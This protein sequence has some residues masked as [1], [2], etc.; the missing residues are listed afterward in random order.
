LNFVKIP[1]QT[2]AWLYCSSGILF[3]SGVIWAVFHYF[4]RSSSPFEQIISPI[5][6]LS[7]K[8]HGAA[9][10]AF[11][12]V[13]GAL[14]PIHMRRAWRGKRNKLSGM[15]ILATCSLLILTGYALYYWGEPASRS[16]ISFIHLGIGILL[17]V[18]LLVHA[19][20]GKSVAKKAELLRNSEPD[21][22]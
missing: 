5:E 19:L 6:P 11:L 20:T 1:T 2:Q 8:I 10:I 13:F 15:V 14:I 7:L 9:A 18:I 17:P 21:K 12:I 4:H 3:V 16:V 22:F